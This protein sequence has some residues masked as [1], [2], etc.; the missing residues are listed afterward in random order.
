M[1]SFQHAIVHIHFLL[2]VLAEGTSRVYYLGIREVEWNY[3]PLQKNEVMGRSIT[4][5]P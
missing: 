5:D 1:G 4:N 2:L 3:A